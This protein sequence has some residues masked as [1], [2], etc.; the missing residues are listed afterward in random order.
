MISFL[1]NVLDWD[2]K[3]SLIVG[4]LF[5]IIFVVLLVWSVS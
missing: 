1:Y 5:D 3:K 4:G 2:L